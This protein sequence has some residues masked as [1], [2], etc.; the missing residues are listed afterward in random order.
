[1]RKGV[2]SSFNVATGHLTISFTVAPNTESARGAAK[3]TLRNSAKDAASII[4]AIQAFDPAAKRDQPSDVGE[5]VRQTIHLD[6]EGAL[7]FKTSLE[8][9]SRTVTLKNQGQ[10]DEFI[11][12]LADIEAT[13]PNTIAHYIR[14]M[15]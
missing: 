9:S 7:C 4:E 14:L 13:E 10:V 12:F 8:K 15:S 11:R 1:M 5:I 3:V 6:D 2:D